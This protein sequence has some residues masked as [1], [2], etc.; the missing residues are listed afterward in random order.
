MV[1]DYPV[2]SINNVSNSCAPRTIGRRTTWKNADG[3]NTRRFSHPK[4]CARCNTSNMRTVTTTVVGGT[5]TWRVIASGNASRCW[6]KLAVSSADARI[7]DV[8]IYTS[9]CRG[10]VITRVICWRSLVN[11]I[12]TPVSGSC[13]ITFAWCRN[14]LVNSSHHFL[15]HFNVSHASEM[16]PSCRFRC[17]EHHFNKVDSAELC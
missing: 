17:S 14:C 10:V 13:P 2:D 11:A 16:R 4:S 12:K 15:I 7:D 9:T 8:N 3:N 5:K 1:A 6:S